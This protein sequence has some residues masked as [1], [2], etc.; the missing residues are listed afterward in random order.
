MGQTCSVAAWQGSGRTDG[1]PPPQIPPNLAGNPAMAAA[2]RAA[3]EALTSPTAIHNLTV[4]QP[5]VGGHVLLH[6]VACLGHQ[7]PK[8]VLQSTVPSCVLWYAIVQA[9]F[10]PRPFAIKD[11]HQGANCV[12]QGTQLPQPMHLGGSL[13]LQ[14]HPLPHLQPFFPQPITYMPALGL[15]LT[16]FAAPWPS[17]HHAGPDLFFSLKLFRTGTAL[18]CKAAKLGCTRWFAMPHAGIFGGCHALELCCLPVPQG[19]LMNSCE[20]QE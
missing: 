2:F 5:Q 12:V 9:R 19:S 11:L 13:L 6:I 1:L 10:L 17:T 15:V 18:H 16:L 14:Q 7:Q 4:P 20:D 8:S 3:F